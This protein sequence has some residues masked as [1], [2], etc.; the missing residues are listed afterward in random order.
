[1]RSSDYS[2]ALLADEMGLGKTV[3][4]IALFWLVLSTNT[5]IYLR[6]KWAPLIN[7]IV[8]LEIIYYSN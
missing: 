7:Y 1:M 8:M 2:G 5:F 3:Q 6:L 4:C